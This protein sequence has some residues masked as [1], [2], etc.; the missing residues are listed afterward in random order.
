MKRK[1]S[2]KTLNEVKIEM[3]CEGSRSGTNSTQTSPQSKRQR[4]SVSV[5][6]GRVF[7]GALKR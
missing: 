4:K 3:E 7:L 5:Q 1:G 6:F 2:V